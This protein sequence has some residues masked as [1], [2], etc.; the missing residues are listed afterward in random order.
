[1][2]TPMTVLCLGAGAV[3]LAVGDCN[4]A[5]AANAQAWVQQIAATNQ[6]PVLLTSTNGLK[7][8]E[9]RPNR[10]DAAAQS[11]LGLLARHEL[12]DGIRVGATQ[13]KLETNC[14]PA[15]LDGTIRTRDGKSYSATTVCGVEPDGLRIE[16]KPIGGGVGMAKLKFKNLP[17]DWQQRYGYDALKAD[18][19]E[20]EQSRAFAEWNA[21]LAAQRN[22][23]AVERMAQGP[24]QDDQQRRNIR[25]LAEIVS[26]YHKKHTY[27]GE[28]IFVC[29]DM[30]CD[31][32]D[33][34]MT[35]GI[36]A[37][38]QVGN[39]ERQITSLHEANHAWVLAETSPGC[40]LA[41][42]TTAGR[43]VYQN[44]NERYYQ[45]WSFANPKEFRKSNKGRG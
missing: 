13:G 30:A 21:R 29:G 44:E 4:R 28:G 40:W 14:A 25:I 35:R 36:N 6:P 33:M 42:E 9:A 7:Q 26:D 16:Y 2:K 12:A 1:M 18:Q 15:E 39:V 8:P 37:K 10:G 19:Y 43:V 31:V 27:L 5:Q 38:I 17:D 32:W 3:C 24:A 11:N 34:V 23:A 20:R 41:L 22:R 45:G